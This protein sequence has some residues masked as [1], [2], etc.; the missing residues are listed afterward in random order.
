[1]HQA[2]PYRSWHNPTLSHS[3]GS[4]KVVIAKVVRENAVIVIGRRGCC[5]T[6][7][8]NHLL[9]GLG[10]NPALHE[11]DDKDEEALAV[12]NQLQPIL[13]GQNLQFPALFIG[14]NL[15]GGLDRLMATHISGHLVP[16]LKQAGAL[17]L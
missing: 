7:V 15:F 4:D 1:M 14:G 2:I 17:W 10:V 3:H 5:M 9:Q 12:A 6:H 8:V 13:N 11:L 16:I